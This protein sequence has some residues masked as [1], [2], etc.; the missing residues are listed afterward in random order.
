MQR[1]VLRRLLQFIPVF[2]GTLFLVHYLTVLGVQINGDPVRAL[3]GEKTPSAGTLHFMRKEFHLDDACLRQTGNP[4]FT[5][6]FD[7]LWSY[8]HGD[9]GINFYR[10]PVTSLISRAWPVT[11]RLALI[12][13]VFQTILGILA[14][15]VSGLRA[16]KA[17]D[18]AVRIST[19]LLVAL[20][21]FVFGVLVQIFAGRYIRDWL[22]SV[23][24]APKWLS[25]VFTTSYSGEHPWLSLIIPG[26]A[27]GAFALASIARLMRT[28][29][30]ENI[31]MDYVRTARAKGLK[32]RRVIGVHLL[33]NSLIP[34]VTYIGIDVGALL[35]G[36][37]VTEGI[38]NVPGVGRL[39]FVAAGNGDVSVIV[40]LVTLLTIIFLFASLAVDILY[41]YLDPRIRY[42]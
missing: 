11:L 30:L 41:A 1:Y 10:Q 2:L 39:T 36:A 21:S 13:I 18:T 12:A 32:R 24:W 16:G 42:D 17:A 22:Q 31:R 19:V 26:F 38:F 23:P 3:F 28:S 33:R 15:I 9:F 20:P 6:F 4:C 8:F 25:Y 27:L 34:V 37:I 29:I 7:R 14:G 35:G 40:A 5:M